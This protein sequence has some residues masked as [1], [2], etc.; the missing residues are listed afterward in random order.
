M[1]R[2]DEIYY[3]VFAAALQDRPQIGLHWFDPFGSVDFNHMVN[4]PAVNRA[5]KRIVFWDQEPFY[6]TTA[7]KFLD[8]F[9]EIYH[10]PITIVTSEQSSDTVQWARSTY[11]IGAD[12]Y[13]FHGWAALD[14]YRGYDRTFLYSPWQLRQFRYTFLCPNNIVGGNRSH[15][16]KL[17][18]ELCRRDLVTKNL[19]SFPLV[20]PYHGKNVHDLC[21]ELEIDLDLTP[22][23]PRTIDCSGD[24]S[25]N[26]HRVD[27]W[28]P[29]CQAFAHV[30]TETVYESDRLHLTEKTFKPIVMQQPFI[31]VAPQG[32]LAYLRSY[33]F[34][35]FANIWD[36]SYDSAPDEIRIHKIADLLY[37]ISQWTDQEIK[38]AQQEIN[39]I[40]EHNHRWF[41][42]DFE[43][44]LWQEI[45]DMIGKW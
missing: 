32:S 36:E 35:T 1:I 10:G 19:I 34:K 14:W 22:W 28:Q 31:L 13:F 16:V 29:G 11:R 9:I 43:T 40:I 26:S 21:Q 25:N 3:N 7:Q 30:V 41:Y 42:N 8:Q 4:V 33:G 18:A 27:F 37:Q 38:C 17:F 5:E 44:L 20:C 2:I 24:H 15:R 6:Q 12:Y 39:H 45:T 23:L